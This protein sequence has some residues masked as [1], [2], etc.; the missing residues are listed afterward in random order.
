MLLFFFRY[1]CHESESDLSELIATL[2]T[3]KYPINSPNKRKR[4]LKS[5]TQQNGAPSSEQV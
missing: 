4:P 5:S 3:S 2:L 1:W